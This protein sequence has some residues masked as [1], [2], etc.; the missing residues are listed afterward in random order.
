M[1]IL[2]E[3]TSHTT[4]TSKVATIPKIKGCFQVLITFL[5]LAISNP[6]LSNL[7]YMPLCS[8]TRMTTQTFT[9]K[10]HKFWSGK[11]HEHIN[12]KSKNYL[13]DLGDWSNHDGEHF[14][15]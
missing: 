5:R 4:L 7:W 10:T 1:C 2:L 13:H 14:E 11:Q 6:F 12:L 3:N 9:P 8:T 15:K